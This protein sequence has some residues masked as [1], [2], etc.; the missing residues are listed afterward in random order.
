MSNLSDIEHVSAG[1]AFDK[2]GL[3]HRVRIPPGDG[4]HPALVMV[5]GLKG[6]EDVTWIF[7]RAA[8]PEWLIVSPRAPFACED[9]YSW[10]QQ[11][12]E[13]KNDLSAYQAGLD[14]FSQFIERLPETYGADKNRVVLLGFSQGAAMSY[15]YG[16]ANPV[17][18]IAALAGFIPSQLAE[19]LP[20]LSN[21]PV[22]MLHGTKDE[23]IPITI[24]RQN[25][26]QLTT[27][28]AAVTYQEAEV[29]H[30]VSSAGIAELKR[31]LAERFS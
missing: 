27:A 1:P 25:R 3:V 14:A 29:G 15:L 21:L 31:W 5:H 17:A 28:G 6:T 23:T 8:R 22:L 20:A 26:D 13:D 12:E 19:R 4:P 16:S 24:A 18:G 7:A 30:K 9:G 10:T 2:L 11:G